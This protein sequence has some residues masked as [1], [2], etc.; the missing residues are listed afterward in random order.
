MCYY[1]YKTSLKDWTPS[2]S[3]GSEIHKEVDEKCGSITC[4][5]LLFNK[6]IENESS[7][8]TKP[9]DLWTSDVCHWLAEVGL[10]SHIDT[11]MGNEILGE[12]LRDLTRD[13]LKVLGITKIGHI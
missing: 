11:F 13:D 12:H 9:L 10:D 6:A 7:F 1:Y 3:S 2:V 4:D 5:L 8:A